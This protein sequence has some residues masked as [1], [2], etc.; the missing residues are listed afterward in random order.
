VKYRPITAIKAVVVGIPADLYDYRLMNS[1][2]PP[3]QVGY[4]IT[5][6]TNGIGLFTS[7]TL[8]EF[9]LDP[10]LRS[11]DSIVQGTHTKH[12]KFRFY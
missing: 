4:P 7:Q 5:N 2:Q 3:D 10:D 8:T 1:V 6:I 12:L 9:E 11:R